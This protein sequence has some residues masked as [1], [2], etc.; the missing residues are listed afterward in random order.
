MH[1]SR[2]ALA[3]LLFCPGLVFAKPAA[4]FHYLPPDAVDLQT[5]LSGPP[6][7]GSREN[8][9]DIQAVLMRQR[10]RTPQEVARAQSEV[11]LTPMAFDTIFGSNFNAAAFPLTFA[12]LGNATADAHAIAASAK[13]FWQRARPPLQD[14][15]IHPVVPIPGNPS[16]PS[17]HAVQ[18]ALWAAILARLAPAWKERILARGDQIGTDR[19][20]AGVHFPTDVAAGQQLGRVL[21][22]RF[23]RDPAFDAD[24]YNAAQK[25]FARFRRRSVAIFPGAP[26]A[27]AW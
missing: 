22:Q 5:I 15:G 14:K 24:L 3:L 27:L 12:L 16:Y 25:E 9:A 1:P 20:I 19:V 23:A 2:I 10:N 18:G 21:A 4:A 7:P 17:F 26:F 8:E 11:D 13:Q 6:A